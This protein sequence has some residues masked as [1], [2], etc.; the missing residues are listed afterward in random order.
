MVGADS[1]RLIRGLGDGRVPAPRSN[2]A[3][4]SG[5]SAVVASRVSSLSTPILVWSAT[6]LRSGHGWRCV[7]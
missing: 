3:F 7:R 2:S 1:L 6:V 4:G 5:T